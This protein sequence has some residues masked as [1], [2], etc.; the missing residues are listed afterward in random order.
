MG[1]KNRIAKEILPIILNGETSGIYEEPFCGG[2]NT[3]DKVPNTFYKIAS[4]SNN[5]LIEMFK[6]LQKGNYFFNEIPKDIYDK[7]RTQYNNDKNGKFI[8][9]EN[10]FNNAQIGWI[11]FM[12]SDN[13]RFFDG[14]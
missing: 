2:C 1:S 10:Y 11:G 9:S 8:I 13:G 5:Y 14:G 3:M 12:A 7:A 6:E 4:D